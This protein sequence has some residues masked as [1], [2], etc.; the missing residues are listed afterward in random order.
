MDIDLDDAF[1]TRLQH[2]ELFSRNRNTL[3]YDSGFRQT[4]KE[5]EVEFAEYTA[6]VPGDDIRYIDWNV[7]ARLNTYVVKQFGSEEYKRVGIVLDSSNSM[8]SGNKSSLTAQLAFSLSCISLFAGDQV[9]LAHINNHMEAY[10]GPYR[11]RTRTQQILSFIKD[12]TVQGTTDMVH[13]LSEVFRL[14]KEPARLFVITDMWSDYDS[15]R[16]IR[17]LGSREDEVCLV[18]VYNRQEIHP[19]FNGRMT[20]R[21]ME[22]GRETRKY[23]GSRTLSQYRK[24]TQEFMERVKSS[25]AR[26]RIEYVLV[27]DSLSVY[28]V[29]FGIMVEQG[30]IHPVWL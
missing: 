1:I 28:E 9:M 27:D 10:A 2:L 5:G 16:F 6:Y 25:C 8:N 26:N 30:I 21:D 20:L 11:G 3:F 18:H 7:Y 29:V 14:W 4:R 13:G 22:T 23:I 15:E 12:I 19:S 24:T 17:F